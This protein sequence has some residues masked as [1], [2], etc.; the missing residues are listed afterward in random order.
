MSRASWSHVRR[1]GASETGGKISVEPIVCG[2]CGFVRK[3]LATQEPL[4]RFSELVTLRHT[5]SGFSQAQ[6]A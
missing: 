6:A 4:F 5:E 2:K 3:K 1:K